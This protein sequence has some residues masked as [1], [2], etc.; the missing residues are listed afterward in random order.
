MTNEVKK[1]T[2][3]QSSDRYNKNMHTLPPPWTFGSYI[4]MI[5]PIDNW[6]MR[7]HGLF[8]LPIEIFSVVK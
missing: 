6:L 1:T 4:F 5:A 7:K 8:I 3:Y 2:G